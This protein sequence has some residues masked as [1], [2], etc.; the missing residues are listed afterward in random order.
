VP[1]QETNPTTAPVPDKPASA[2]AKPASSGDKP[3]AAHTGY[4]SNPFDFLRPAWEG[5]KLNAG[6]TIGVFLAIIGL[7]VVSVGI[8][9][10]AGFGSHNIGLTVLLALVLAIVDIVVIAT[11]LAPAAIRLQLA[12]ARHQK[13]TWSEA[14]ANSVNVGWRLFGAGLLTGLAVLGG[15]ILLIVP[16]IIFAVWF[17]QSAYAIVAEDLGVIDGMKRS[18]QLVRNR[19]W[20][21]LGVLCF[22]Q[23]TSIFSVIPV[24]GSLASLVINIALSPMQTI[25]Y[26]QLV[27]LKKTSDGKGIPTHPANFILI[28]L[29]LVAGGMDSASQMSS[30][31]TTQLE[32]NSSPY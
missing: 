10:A 17:S 1:S 21:A 6:P 29:A 5:F 28:V 11:V 9:V 31:A 30:P 24:L 3:A 16:G 12:S 7:V 26:Y 13:L 25:R 20:D 27:E 2:P 23:A 22:F 14:R 8:A 19:F 32:K 4:Q 18:R 15:L